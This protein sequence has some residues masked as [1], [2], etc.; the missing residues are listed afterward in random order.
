MSGLLIGSGI[1][2]IGSI[3][4]SASLKAVFPDLSTL[5]RVSLAILGRLCNSA[6]FAIAYFYAA[7]LFPT[8]VRYV[9]ESGLVH[10]DYCMQFP[11]IYVDVNCVCSP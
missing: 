5:I 6:A 2:L 7:E 9:E 8:E 4:G 10:P 3:L 1:C 11:N